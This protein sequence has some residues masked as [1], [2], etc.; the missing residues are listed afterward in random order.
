MDIYVEKEVGMGCVCV[1]ERER[2]RERDRQ[3]DRQTDRQRQTE[4]ETE[5]ER[6]MNVYEVRRYA[7]QKG[8]EGRVVGGERC[9][10]A[11]DN[12]PFSPNRFFKNRVKKNVFIAAKRNMRIFGVICSK[13]T[14]KQQLNGEK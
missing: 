1:R 5:T 13:R 8:L 4:I 12:S 2:D 14:L 7:G 9:L 3:T 10:F 11:S 6:Q